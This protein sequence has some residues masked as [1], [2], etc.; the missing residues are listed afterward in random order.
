[1]GVEIVGRH[2]TGPSKIRYLYAQ[3]RQRRP[4]LIVCTEVTPV[5]AAIRYR[6]T[7]AHHCTVIADITEWYPEQSVRELQGLRKIVR[8]LLLYCY[9]VMVIRRCDALFVG[10]EAKAQRYRRI[11]PAKPLHII[12]YYP[13]L[14][15]FPWAPSPFTQEASCFTCAMSGILSRS[16]GV[17]RVIALWENLARGFPHVC[18]RL[19]LVGHL[20]QTHEGRSVQARLA[21]VQ[22]RVPNACWEHREWRQYDAYGDALQDADVCCDL[23][24]ITPETDRSFPIKLYDYLALGKPVIYSRLGAIVH[25]YSDIPWIGLV[26]PQCPE[27]ALQ[28]AGAYVEDASALRRHSRAARD[29]IEA[30]LAWEHHEARFVRIVESY[31]R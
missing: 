14:R 18:I 1:M 26:D 31:L 27:D 30:G 8:Y 3:C 17:L 29:M 9:N 10:E 25:R 16:R 6:R 5:L 23:R 19:L 21:R 24:D 13:V 7:A 11:A 4:R 12:G 28:A 22:T 15:Y 20:G 2:I